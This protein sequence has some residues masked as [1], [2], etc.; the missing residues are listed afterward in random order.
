MD[1]TKSKQTNRRLV[2]NELDVNNKQSVC[3]G[4]TNRLCFDSQVSESKKENFHLD[5]SRSS[6]NGLRGEND[7]RQ[8]I[9][10]MV[11]L[12]VSKPSHAKDDLK[13]SQRLPA[14]I[15]NM[16]TSHFSH[17]SKQTQPTETTKQAA[18]LNTSS[19]DIPSN[20]FL[21]GELPFQTPMA[22]SAMKELKKNRLIQGVFIVAEEKVKNG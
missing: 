16:T 9:D 18:G 22:Q 10:A 7:A 17:D 11:K 14:V 5:S 1:N 21:K 3:E 8:V 20:T 15:N 19:K 4:H 13:S 6:L 12:A 2:T